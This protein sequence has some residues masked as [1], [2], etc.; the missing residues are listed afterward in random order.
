MRLM[1][2]EQ[3][4]IWNPKEEMTDEDNKITTSISVTRN[5]CT[6]DDIDYAIMCDCSRM[7]RRGF[8]SVKRAAILDATKHRPYADF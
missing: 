8:N 4:E 5:S 1:I 2:P 3:T 6:M 7:S